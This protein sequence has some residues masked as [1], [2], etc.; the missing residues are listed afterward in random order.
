[1]EKVADLLLR[2]STLQSEI[3]ATVH[4]VAEDM[5]EFKDTKPTERD[6][7]DAVMKWKQ[8]RKPTLNEKM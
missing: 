5:K 8:R 3:A 1:M 4:F 7:L 6:V 2:T